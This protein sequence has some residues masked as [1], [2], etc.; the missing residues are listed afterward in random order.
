MKNALLL[1]AII[2]SLT[3]PGRGA[4]M[5]VG[6]F[7]SFRVGDSSMVQG[8]YTQESRTSLVAA[9]PGSTFVAFDTI[10][11]QA[12][13]GVTIAI[14]G[15]PV[16]S[17]PATTLSSAEQTALLNFIRAGHGA[18]IYL[19]NSDFSGGPTESF[20]DPFGMHLSGKVQS[21][22]YAT[23]IAPNHP[24]MK[25]PFGVVT[26]FAT[27]YGGW[28]DDLGPN[29]TALANYDA[30]GLPAVAAIPPGALGPGSG[31]V[32][33]FGDADSL[34]DSAAGGLFHSSDNEKLFLNA[35]A[36]VPEPSTFSLLACTGLVL[37]ARRR[38]DHH[39][40]L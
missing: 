19:D 6:G 33:F 24:V 1:L 28:F 40:Y 5:V 31:G 37:A 4:A 15:S 2:A 10:T 34:V 9:F 35:V 29:A 22:A 17:P 16:F 23:S 36:F 21:L 13:N 7:S 11:P 38:P 32:V 3:T 25:Q 20:L 26:T 18:I 12:L 30:N 27:S 39:A 8:P 14:V